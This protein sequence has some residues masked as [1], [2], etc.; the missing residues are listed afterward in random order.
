[1]NEVPQWGR[2][3]RRVR[4][5]TARVLAKELMHSGAPS[6]DS[7]VHV[8][9]WFLETFTALALLLAAPKIGRAVTAMMLLFMVAC[10]VH[11]FWHFRIVQR[12]S[13]TPR[14]AWRFAGLM[15]TALG[16]I[17]LF[18]A[19]VW[20]PIKRHTLSAD[21]RSS[22]RGALTGQ[23]DDLDVQISCPTGDEKTCTYAE[24]FINLVGASGWKVEPYVARVTLSR[25]RDGV[26]IYRRGGNK[27]YISKHWDAGGY[28]AINEPH[29]L[30]MQKAFQLIH[31][32][33]EGGT[34]PDLA[35]NVMTV[36]FGP[37]KDNE[38]EPTGLTRSTEWV[39]GKRTGPFPQPQQ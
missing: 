30:A 31:I 9:L 24:Q 8:A 3:N 22:F 18:G 1:M 4:R 39:T 16:L 26:T 27:D 6:H 15:I 20:P 10:L 33:P 13:S 14:R 38:A 29:L 28:F 12:T 17:A 34:N 25:A 35:E 21:E 36:Y 11:P 7:R 5:E 23:K 2:E 32:E 19:Y 37:E